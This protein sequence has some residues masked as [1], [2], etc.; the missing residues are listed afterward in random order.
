[1][2]NDFPK[3]YLK[4]ICC[5]KCGSDLIEQ[6][7]FLICKKCDEKY[8]IQSGIPILV[9]LRNLPI[10]LQKQIKYFE[11]E[12]KKRIEY[13]LDEW[14]RSY[15]RKFL[16]NFGCNIS[17]KIIVDSGTGSGYMAIELAK[18][19]ATVIACDLTFNNLV[20]LKQIAEELNIK[21]INFICCKAE[22]LPFRNRFA[23]F[24]ILNAVLE[25]LAEEKKTIDEISRICKNVAG[26]MITAPLKFRY[27]NPLFI[28]IN[29]L[30]D[31]RIGHLRRY[32]KEDLK[33]KFYN[34]KLDSIYYTGHF[35]KVL[36]S[37]FQI[38]KLSLFDDRKIEQL[39][40]KKSSKKYG[41]SNICAIFKR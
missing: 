17:D 41:A 29:Y 11:N 14:Q 39:D 32:D 31:K 8:K 19:G 16:D 30:Y 1:M 25:H 21:N 38:A 13:K 22:K 37:I 4:Y 36:H 28:P 12:D 3:N 6:N 33:R 20:K 27:L 9:N 24:F 15:V 40:D 18:L 5:P 34:W 35:K 10:H 2:N 26:L 7:N 23:D